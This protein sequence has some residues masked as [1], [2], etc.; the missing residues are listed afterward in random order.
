MPRLF[1]F[2][3]FGFKK[4]FGINS[5]RSKEELVFRIRGVYCANIEG[6][7]II[8]TTQRIVFVFVMFLRHF[9]DRKPSE[10]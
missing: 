8:L 10:N 5:A 1:L 9:K 7:D 2:F 4:G 3:F 6:I